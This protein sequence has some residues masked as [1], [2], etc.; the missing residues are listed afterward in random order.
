MIK[1]H[2]KPRGFSF[3]LFVKDVWSDHILNSEASSDEDFCFYAEADGEQYHVKVPARSLALRWES[4][5]INQMI[6]SFSLN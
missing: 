4:N 6:G 5:K 1:F 3:D 2:V